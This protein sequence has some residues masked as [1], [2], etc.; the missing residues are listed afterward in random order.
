M[1]R[2]FCSLKQAAD[3]LKKTEEEL[4][5]MVKQGKLREFGDGPNVLL[6]VNE[7]E[8]LVS[9]EGIEAAREVPAA[10]EPTPEAIGP[11]AQ[12]PKAPEIEARE[13]ESEQVEIPELE[14]L[15]PDKPESVIAQEQAVDLE[16]SDLEIPELETTDLKTWTPE[17]AA[18]EPELPTSEALAAE[19]PTAE[20]LKP[21]ETSASPPEIAPT[22]RLNAQPRIEGTIYSRRL[23]IR[24]WLLKGLRQ[25]NAAA[26]VV[27][28]LLLCVILSACAVLGYVLYAIF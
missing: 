1:V 14:S 12:K 24:Q 4:K 8:A 13:L 18:A 19:T 23:S 17:A 2:T 26:V 16:A 11:E 27:F 20:A 25:D 22:P 15:E 3:R 10:E 9:E 6:K 28:F 21:E 5:E 7:V